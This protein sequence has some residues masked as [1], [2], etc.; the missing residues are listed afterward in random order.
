M[1][2]YLS[3]A[4]NPDIDGGYWQDGNPYAA[5]HSVQINSVDD[6]PRICRKYIDDNGLGGGNWTGGQIMQD[7]EQ[8]AYVSYNGR[9]WPKGHKYCM[10]F[11][12]H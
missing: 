11:M 2:L 1:K 12:N 10:G 8:V 3:H 9:V 6:A 4:S 5:K 7:G